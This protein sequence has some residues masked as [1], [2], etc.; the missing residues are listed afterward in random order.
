MEKLELAAIIL[1]A[2]VGILS[3]FGQLGTAITL[4][5]IAAP[6]AAIYLLF[7][8]KKLGDSLIA[9]GLAYFQAWQEKNRAHAQENA[10]LRAEI[11]ASV[12]KARREEII[13]QEALRARRN[14]QAAYR[15]PTIRA[16]TTR[17]APAS[18]E[19]A[20]LEKR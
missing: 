7:I 12:G 19:D 8:N 1:V 13:K 15:P 11:A 9:R 5:T 4:L 17:T 14:V 6:A 3:W 16:G 20:I 2:G 18:I 10:I